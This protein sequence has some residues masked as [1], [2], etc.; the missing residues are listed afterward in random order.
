MPPSLS[1]AGRLGSRRRSTSGAAASLL[2]PTALTLSALSLAALTGCAATVPAPIAASSD[3]SAPASAASA[4]ETPSPETFFDQPSSGFSAAIKLPRAVR[5]DPSATELVYTLEVEGREPQR[6]VWTMPL[7]QD[8]SVIALLADEETP[9]AA[10]YVF[11]VPAEAQTRLQEVQR[12]IAGF[13]KT[14]VTGAFSIGVSPRNL[15]RL[16]PLDAGLHLV[17]MYW[18]TDQ[19]AGF[20]PLAADV[21]LRDLL[22]GGPDLFSILPLCD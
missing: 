10:I 7:E 2:G 13:R 6:D 22:G 19:T 12:Q 9:E 3:Q 11:A 8:P 14:G 4:A 5:L 21:D 20:A 15:C 16:A 18:R 17:D 1:M